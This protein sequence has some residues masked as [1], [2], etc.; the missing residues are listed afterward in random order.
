MVVENP[1]PPMPRK[2][3]AEMITEATEAAK[4]VSDPEMRKIAFDKILEFLLNQSDEPKTIM[5]HTKK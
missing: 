4:D 2:T 3:Y 5:E 1:K